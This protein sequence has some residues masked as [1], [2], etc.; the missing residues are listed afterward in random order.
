M[1]NKSGSSDFQPFALVVSGVILLVI[2]IWA[3]SY[4]MFH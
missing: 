4:V 2:S 3:S 1:P